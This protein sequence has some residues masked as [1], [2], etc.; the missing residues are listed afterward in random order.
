MSDTFVEF[1]KLRQS[2]ESLAKAGLLDVSRD[3]RTF[4]TSAKGL[5]YIKMC[6]RTES[7]EQF[8]HSLQFVTQD[9]EYVSHADREG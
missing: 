5:K 7:W 3:F 9:P 1:A 4:K 8:T 2:L 6:E